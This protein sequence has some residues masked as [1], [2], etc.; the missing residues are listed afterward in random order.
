MTKTMY[1]KPGPPAVTQ[2]RTLKLARQ[3]HLGVAH[4]REVEAHALEVAHARE[5]DEHA[6]E[7][8]HAREVEAYALEVANIE[9]S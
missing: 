9:I 1:P 7:I 6:L 5:V 8:A 3:I 2:R 4:D